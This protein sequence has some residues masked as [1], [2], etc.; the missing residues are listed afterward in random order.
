MKN[1]KGEEVDFKL[2][3][4]TRPNLRDPSIEMESYMGRHILDNCCEH[5][6]IDEKTDKIVLSFPERWLN[7]LEQRCLYS[8]IEQ[9]YTNIRK[10]IIKTHS[11]YFVQCTRKEEILIMDK[12]NISEDDYFHGVIPK[13]YHPKMIGNL[14]NATG[15]DFMSFRVPS[16]I[17]DY[18]K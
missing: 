10:V 12:S 8:K 9:L 2:L 5:Q 3:V 6:K 1:Q 17:E 13:A 15:A 16:P 18:V 14:L 7:V 11:V 4:Y